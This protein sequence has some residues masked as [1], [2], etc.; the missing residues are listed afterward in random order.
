MPQLFNI[1]RRI[2]TLTV[3]LFLTN[4]AFS[5]G[6]EFEKDTEV[7]LGYS[8]VQTLALNLNINFKALLPFIS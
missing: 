4:A 3:I 7:F 1:L 2:F 6:A 5:P 8:T